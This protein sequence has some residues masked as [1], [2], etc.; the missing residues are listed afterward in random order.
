[1]PFQTQDGSTLLVP[2]QFVD[3]LRAPRNRRTGINQ[4]PPSGTTVL[5]QTAGNTTPQGTVT[6]VGD[7]YGR[8][9]NHAT[10]ASSGALGGRSVT[11]NF[12]VREKPIVAI[13]METGS[14]FADVRYFCG[15]GTS[16]LDTTDTPGGDNIWFRGSSSTDT[17]WKLLI[18]E[19]SGGTTT[20]VD[21]GVAIAVSTRYDFWIGCPGDGYAYGYVG[22]G[23]SV[24]GGP[25]PVAIPSAFDQTVSENLFC[26][27][28]N[29]AASAKAIRWGKFYQNAE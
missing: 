17:T 27:C 26:Q 8:W 2:T 16:G 24:M 23:G 7:A 18:T 22:V 21:T 1:M 12:L 15:F 9:L 28:E 20:I 19:S 14:S 3:L 29:K 5:T 25:V 4:A 11:A 13:T 6:N 10:A